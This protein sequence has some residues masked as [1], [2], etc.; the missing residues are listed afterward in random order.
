MKKFKIILL[1]TAT[2][3][4]A[5][6]DQKEAVFSEKP[7]LGV[8]LQLGSGISATI[9]RAHDTTWDA[10]DAIG[11]FTTATGTTTITKS[12]SQYDENI[13]YS[14][15][16]EAETY[17]GGNYTYRQFSPLNEKKIYL[18][19]DGSAVDVYAYYPYYNT[20]SATVSRSISIPTPQTLSNQK[21]VDV[22]KAKVSSTPSAPVDIDHPSVNLLFEHVMSKVIVYVMSGTGY[23]D[24]DLTGDKVSSVQLLGQPTEATFAPISQE[25]T[26]TSGNNTITMQEITDPTDPD[27]QTTYT[28][29]ETS[30]PKNVLHVYRAI[31]LPNNT[32]TNPVTSGSERQI[33]FNV[34]ATNYTYDITQTFASGQETIF[35]MRLS[36]T[37]LDV[38]A[39][40]R[41]WSHETITPNPLYP[42]D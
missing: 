33:K 15:T 32:S 34:G 13:G 3:L 11:V 21:Q 8:P 37:G 41:D 28:I 36:A 17:S 26:I 10:G 6:C 30:T 7:A 9:T 19:A 14:T 12:G 5:S 1:L 25:L 24:E 29:P 39:A 42:Q 4:L 40:I 27:Y 2:I 16:L 31:I 20:V 35:A 23:G 22:L 38:W 18:P